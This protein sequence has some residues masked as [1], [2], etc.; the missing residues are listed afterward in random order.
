MRDN[1]S[2]VFR[3]LGTYYAASNDAP[4][5]HAGPYQ[6]KEQALLEARRIQAGSGSDPNFVLDLTNAEPHEIQEYLR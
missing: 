1:Y 5:L 3:H 2:V 4:D 6:T